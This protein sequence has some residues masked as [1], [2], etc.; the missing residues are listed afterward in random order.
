MCIFLTV[1]ALLLGALAAVA[2][3]WYLRGLWAE[4]E[5]EV[6]W[7]AGIYTGREYERACQHAVQTNGN[8]VPNLSATYP[9]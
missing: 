6:S 5:T 8:A 1:A 4:H 2:L 7:Q 9:G 3:G